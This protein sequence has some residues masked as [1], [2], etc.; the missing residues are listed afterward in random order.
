MVVVLNTTF[1]AIIRPYLIAQNMI[2]H[3]ELF[4]GAGGL[5]LGLHQAGLVQASIAVDNNDDCLNTLNANKAHF[6]AMIRINTDLTKDSGKAMYASEVKVLSAGF[7]C[8]PFSSAAAGY[9]NKRVLDVNGAIAVL[10][11]VRVCNPQLAIFENVLGFREVDNGNTF[12]WFM[13]TLR[14]LGYHVTSEGFDMANYGVPQHRQRL[15]MIA[16]KPHLP[17]C[18]FPFLN[19][20]PVT[21]VTTLRAALQDVPPSIGS[22]FQPKT[23]ENYVNVAPGTC[24]RGNGTTQRWRRMSW[25]EPALTITTTSTGQSQMCHPDELRPFTVREVA[26]IQT[27]PDDYVFTGN[28]SAQYRQI[29]NAV[30]P[31]FVK[32]LGEVIKKRLM[33]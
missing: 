21:P 10:T 7:P 11:H 32:K 24:R 33:W 12:R 13:S 29:G 25:D 16:W 17:P 6:G 4:A 2:D 5:A 9:R 22:K 31:L 30:P 3:L 23:A 26:R 19:L 14:E 28:M 18:G 1:D 8:Q 15:I 20:T 27:F